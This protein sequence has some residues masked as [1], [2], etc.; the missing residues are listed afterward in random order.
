MSAQPIPYSPDLEQVAPDEA[1]TEAGLREEM[2]RILETTSQ[3]YGTAVRSVHA[4]GHALVTGTL[5]VADGLP[6]ELAQGLFA[7]GGEFP[8]TMRF[9]TNAGDIMDD[10]VVLPRGCAIKI[11][12]DRAERG[13]QDFVLVNGPAF[14]APDPKAFLGNLKLLSRTTDKAEGLKKAMSAVLRGTERALEAVGLESAMAKTM[15][16]Q[17]STHPA[18]DTYYSQT[19]F[20]YGAYVAK[21]ALK[22]VSANLTSRT[23]APVSVT[24]RPDA[25]REDLN[26]AFLEADSVWELQVQLCTDRDA[27]PIEDASKAWDE[28][29]SPYRT[30]GRL[31]VPHQSGWENGVSE[32][33]EGELLFTPWHCLDEHRPLGGVNRARRGIYEMSAEFRAKFNGCPVHQ[34]D[35]ATTR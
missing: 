34:L 21:V 33:R 23:D 24:G 17:P 35:G 1:E 30:V 12:T 19:P 5:T 11:E 27:M 18:G 4:K 26:E 28:S 16:G 9:S 32:P 20:R 10:S 14:A 29:E 8:V 3:D 31:T 15:G 13:S 22:P 25:L 6:E 7:Q 2:T